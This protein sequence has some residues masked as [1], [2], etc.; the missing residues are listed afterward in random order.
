MSCAAGRAGDVPAAVAAAVTAAGL[1]GARVAVGLS[2]GVDSVVLLH[3]MHGLAPSLGLRLSALH[4]HHGLS[5]HATQWTDHCVAI[6][7]SLGIALEVE[8]VTI[9]RRDPRG[10]EAAARAERYRCYRALDA[11]AVALAHHLDD[12]AETVLLQ[13]L[14]GAGLAGLAA[15]PAVRSLGE[16]CPRLVRPLLDV[17]RTA[18]EAHARAAGLAWIEDESNRDE[19]HARN[20]IRAR[21]LPLIESRFPAC[22]DTLARSARNAAEGAEIVAHVARADLA[23]CAAGPGI[24]LAALARL[25]TARQAGALRLW[26]AER[27]I[28]APNRERLLEG[29]DQMLRAPADAQPVLD[30]GTRRLVR[31]RGR[32]LLAEAPPAAGTWTVP[33]PGDAPSVA[34]PDG[35][36]VRFEAVRGRGLRAEALRGR[37]V[38]LSGRRGG[39][40]MRAA[41]GRPRRTLKNLLQEQG[42]PAWDRARLVLLHVDGELVHVPGVATD[43]AFVAGAEDPGIVVT[44]AS[45]GS[46]PDGNAG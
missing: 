26:L 37:E 12:Q 42:V 31:H 22:R 24:E 20:F 41:A 18:I 13:L 38:T 16:G 25:D 44:V 9:S 10:I 43:P 39:E 40:R 1:A 11:D 29:M 45:P 46:S 17:P 14:R 19:R 35:R 5:P 4:V 33:W 21:V 2:G 27:G 8:R 34:L 28:E 23:A 6:C 36:V 3:A 15:M 30:L 32:L 7:A